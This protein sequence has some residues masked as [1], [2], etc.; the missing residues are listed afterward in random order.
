MIYSLQDGSLFLIVNLRAM[1]CLPTVT[2]RGEPAGERERHTPKVT[3]I[4]RYQSKYLPVK[5]Q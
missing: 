5:F 2:N 1:V 4:L 3:V